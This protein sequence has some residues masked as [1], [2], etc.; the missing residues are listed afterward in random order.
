MLVDT[1]STDATQGICQLLAKQ[2]PEKCKLYLYDQ[3]VY[4]GNHEK[5]RSDQDNSAH[6]LSYFYNYCMSKASYNHVMKFDDDMLCVGEDFGKLCDL[7]R[8]NNLTYFLDV[9]QINIS[10]DRQGNLAV[11]NKYL[12]S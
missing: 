8:K 10:R 7:I 9:P 4:P 11:A 12:S 5:Y 6:A 1:S 2:Y 3:N